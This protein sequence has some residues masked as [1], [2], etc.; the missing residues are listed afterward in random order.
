MIPDTAMAAALAGQVEGAIDTYANRSQRSRQ[1]EAHIL[2]V[3]DIGS[4]REYVR[5]MIANDPF[6]D[7]NNAYALASFIG[8]AVGDYTETALIATMENPADADRQLTVRIA[9]DNG[10]VLVGHPDLVTSNMVVDVKT[11]PGLSVVRRTGPSTQQRFQ[12]TLYAAALI[13]AGRLPEDAWCAV[14]W[15]DRSGVETRPHVVMWRYDEA[16]LAEATDWVDDVLYALTHNELA[17]RDKPREWCAACCPFF[18]ACRTDTDVQGLIVSPEHREA[19][20]A[21]LDANARARAAE[22]DRKGAQAALLGVSGSTG[23]HTVRWVDVPPSDVA[24]TKAGYSRL[25]VR[26]VNGKKR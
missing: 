16:D 1:S 17:G 9:L 3:S 8:T 12:V 6:T 7:G 22:V 15:I 10:V 19:V 18:S 24:Y 2:G 13:N 5:R 25:D 14:V 26:S 20:E 21:Y 11:V 23:T 4:C